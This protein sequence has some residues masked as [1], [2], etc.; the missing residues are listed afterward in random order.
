MSSRRRHV[1]LLAAGLVAAAWAVGAGSA[2]AQ[3]T[4]YGPNAPP[5]TRWGG[6]PAETPPTPAAPEANAAPVAPAPRQ[7]PPAPSDELGAPPPYAHAVPPGYA[8]A[9]PLDAYDGALHLPLDVA[10]RMRAI[11]RDLMAVG[12]RGSTNIIDGIISA[13]SGAALISLALY[14]DLVDTAT[15]AGNLATFL[16]VSGAGLLARSAVELFVEPNPVEPAVHYAHLPMRSRAEADLRLR[17]G[18]GALANLASRYSA[19]RVIES[20]ISIT[21][22]V[23]LC[24]A[25]YLPQGGFVSSNPF[26]WIVAI[27]AGISVV[28]GFATLLTR[29]DAERRWEAYRELRDH[30]AATPIQAGVVPVPGGAAAT[31]FG[32]F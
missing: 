19:S 32:H 13:A 20:V 10:A 24:F 26:S 21:S 7:I 22:A 6:L 23:G 29:S 15:S 17:Y 12:A 8:V 5:P 16:Y 9:P 25:Y 31:V 30:L 14:F 28:T 18:E 4:D 3:E 27:T 2:L 1:G 11:D